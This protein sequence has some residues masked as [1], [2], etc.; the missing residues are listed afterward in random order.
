MNEPFLCN[1]KGHCVDVIRKEMVVAYDQ[2][3]SI[4]LFAWKER[5]RAR[6]RERTKERKKERKKDRNTKRSQYSN[7]V[8]SNANLDLNRYTKPACK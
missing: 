1:L 7:Q 3:S 6:E 2:I 4:P 5:Y 8:F